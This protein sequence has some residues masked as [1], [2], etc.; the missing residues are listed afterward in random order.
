MLSKK[1]F[2]SIIIFFLSLNPTYA[3]NLKDAVLMK[4]T[5]K[6]AVCNN[7]E[8]STFVLSKSNS[9]NWFVYFQGGGVASNPDQYKNRAQ[10]HKKPKSKNELLS[11]PITMD[12]KDKN[13]NILII[14]YC[15]SDLHIGSHINVIDGQDVYYHGRY[16]IKNIFDMMN[17]SF[18]ASENLIF[19]GY[20]AGAIALGLNSDLIAQYKNSKV[21]VDSF[22]LDAESRRLRDEWT[23]GPWP[24]I[25]QFL[26]G[27]KLPKHCNNN[28]Q[29]CF[30]QKSKFQDMGIDDVF[31]IWNIGDAYMIGDL[32]KNKKAIKDDIKH[33]NAGFSIDAVKLNADGFGIGHVITAN[34]L[35][36]R[37]FNGISLRELIHNWMTKSDQTS[38]VLY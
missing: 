36:T 27:D 37:K 34:E 26:Y 17:E 28:W 33:Y 30:A 16:I 15:T 38:L 4:T 25:V 11:Y 24:K 14:P 7:G 12:F 35:Y 32:D 18:A 13:Y 31:P 2:F 9:K 8:Q 29:S 3:D 20:S 10:H 5:D 21:I 22:W 19:A 1:F 23:S 6:N